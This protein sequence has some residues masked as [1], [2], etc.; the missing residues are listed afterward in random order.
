MYSLGNIIDD[1]QIDTVKDYVKNLRRSGY[2]PSIQ[3]LQLTQDIGVHLEKNM[4]CIYT[5]NDE[6]KTDFEE[7][8]RKAEFQ[9]ARLGYRIISSQD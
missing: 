8:V 9:V 1:K 2:D 5:C 3:Q 7:Y 6:D 4:L